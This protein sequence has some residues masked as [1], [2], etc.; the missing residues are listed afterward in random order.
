MPGVPR[1]ARARSPSFRFQRARAPHVN[2]HPATDPLGLRGPGEY[3]AGPGSAS[4]G[5]LFA[6]TGGG[7]CEPRRPGSDALPS[8][9]E[10][11]SRS[12]PRGPGLRG[13]AR[14]PPCPAR[15]VASPTDPRGPAAPSRLRPCGPS[16]PPPARIFPGARLLPPSAAGRVEPGS[17]GSRREAAPRPAS[18]LARARALQPWPPRRLPLPPSPL[19]PRAQGRPVGTAR[20]GPRGRGGVSRRRR[21]ARPGPG[22]GRSVPR[23]ARAAP[24]HDRRRRD[25]RRPTT[26]PPPADPRCPPPTQSRGVPDLWPAAAGPAPDARSPAPLRVPARWAR[27]RKDFVLARSAAAPR[28]GSRPDLPA[29]ADPLC[30]GARVPPPARSRPVSRRPQ[31]RPRDASPPAA[32]SATNGATLPGAATT[33][34]VLREKEKAQ[35]FFF[36]FQ[37]SPEGLLDPLPPE[38]RT[39]TN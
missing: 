13:P 6:G 30:R 37:R 12:A 36:A 35:I 32:R 4:G 23:R 14:P 25:A 2:A 28:T 29:A 10:A 11:R 21:R 5:S 16:R 26:H 3:I 39:S 38:G 17:L 31:R 7:A 24:G 22:P 27:G 34:L 8:P 19:P 33:P 20:P 9:G 1:D 18:G 15:P